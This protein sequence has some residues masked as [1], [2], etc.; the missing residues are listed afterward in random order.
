[1]IMEPLIW[2]EPEWLQDSN[3]GVRFEDSKWKCWFHGDKRCDNGWVIPDS[4]GNFSPNFSVMLYMAK[5]WTLDS[6]AKEYGY[7]MCH[8]GLRCS[9]GLHQW[10]NSSLLISNSKNLQW[11]IYASC[12]R[13]M[14]SPLATPSCIVNLHPIFGSMYSN[15]SLKWNRCLCP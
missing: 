1:M 12:N 4:W 3:S 13:P 9:V 2:K 5:D 14:R 8:R 10:T 7:T 11:P 6:L 15:Y